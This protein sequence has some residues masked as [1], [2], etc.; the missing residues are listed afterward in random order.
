MLHWLSKVF[1]T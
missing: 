1:E